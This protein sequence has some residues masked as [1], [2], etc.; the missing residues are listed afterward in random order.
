M[1]L[2]PLALALA[3]L[4]SALLPVVAE[5]RGQAPP[6]A[7]AAIHDPRSGLALFGHDPVAYHA[8]GRALEGRPDIAAR[9]GGLEW[10]FVSA[11]NRAAFEADPAAY[12]PALSGHDPVAAEA[13]A[14]A[15][16]DPAHFLLVGHRL[17]L[18]R[19]A[20]RRDAARDNLEIIDRAEAA[21]QALARAQRG[22]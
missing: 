17:Y 9:H 15:A 22:Q 2:R 14:M 11:A 3:L 16:G 8:E 1:P 4:P 6:P 12:L 19:S 18:F 20:E 7:V 21:W 5:A 13:G 10:R